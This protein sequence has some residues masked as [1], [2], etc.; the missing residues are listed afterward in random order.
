VEFIVHDSH[1]KLVGYYITPYFSVLDHEVGWDFIDTWPVVRTFSYED[2]D[3]E[4]LLAI[5]TGKVHADT[6]AATVL[7]YPFEQPEIW[8][9]RTQ[10]W[11]FPLN[12]GDQI[13]KLYTIFREIQ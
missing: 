5:Y 6:V 8:L 9:V 10:T 3:Y 11:G 12:E 13:T 2:K 7:I 1:G 4:V